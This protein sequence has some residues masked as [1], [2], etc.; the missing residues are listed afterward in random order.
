[1]NLAKNTQTVNAITI[2][3]NLLCLSYNWLETT[4]GQCFD[5]I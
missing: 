5:W 4:N 3:S 2:I 1:M